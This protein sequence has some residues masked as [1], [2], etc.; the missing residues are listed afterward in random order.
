MNKRVFA[1]VLAAMMTLFL[2]PSAA[3][4]TGASSVYVGGVLLDS[5]NPYLV[6]GAA[7]GSG[8]LGADG[9]TA[10]FD[11]VTATLTLREANIT[12]SYQNGADS[13]KF[14]IYSM[15]GDLTIKL[16]GSNTVT[17]VKAETGASSYGIYVMEGSLT[18]INGMSGSLT[19]TGADGAG[20]WGSAA[21][22]ASYGVFVNGVSLNLQGQTAER[23]SAGIYSF[24]SVSI[25]NG[26]DVTCA[27]GAVNY[28]GS[29]SD[30][31]CAN[32]ENT[33]VTVTDSTLTS[34]GNTATGEYST[35]YGVFARSGFAV[36]NSIVY[37][38]GDDWAVNAFSAQP[39]GMTVTGSVTF[40]AA[41]SALSSATWNGS[42]NYNISS[43][44][45]YSLTKTLKLA[46]PV[47]KPVPVNETVAP[48]VS[49]YNASSV[50]DATVWLT[51]VGLSESDMLV[52]ERLTS[53]SDYEAM[54][55][56]ANG[57]DIFR[58]YEI[59]LRSGR[60][61][62][63]GAML[64]FFDLADRYAGQAFTLVHKKSDSTFE[65]FY[66]T[67]DKAGDLQFGPLYDLSPF[68]LVKGT[69]TQGY[70]DIPQTGGD[71]A[72]AFL[73]GL[74]AI[75]LAAAGG[76]LCALRRRKRGS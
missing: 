39:E 60:K 16:I 20:Q 11:S 4:A 23:V 19:A 32:A 56:L 8:T 57:E 42:N 61:S 73:I 5:T 70:A 66:A 3:L 22:F 28:K 13:D 74:A 31:I 53:G 6:G 33:T 50:S 26:A 45:V 59:Y 47:A 55:R 24:G 43:G 63:G 38:S 51:G 72:P 15:N 12:G 17:G 52:T 10:Y 54:R 30:G 40:K 21:I 9:C 2:L 1:V 27:S 58:I 64:L 46:K 41:E 49:V 67:A 76:L 35:S 62:T 7:A 14:G 75:G 18:I 29:F 36:S 25:S 37:I 71:T 69:L 34:T 68:M 48:R 65:Y 44:G